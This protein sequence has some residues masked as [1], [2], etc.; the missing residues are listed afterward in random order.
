VGGGS[1]PR[2]GEISLAHHGVLFL[3]ELSEFARPSLEALRQP[4][5]EGRVAVVRGQLARMFP[6]RF[7]L[8]AATNP[9]P[10]GFA[11]D[12][13][14]SC[15]EAEIARHR[16]RLS[17]PLLDRLDLVV[18]VQRVTSAEL[19]AGPVCS[20]AE[21]RERVAAARERQAHRLAGS[22]ARCNGQMDASMVRAHVRLSAGAQRALLDAYQE[23]RLS[24]R[25]HQRVLRV[26]RTIADLEG[27]E[28][29]RQ[30]HV[31]RALQLRQH[32]GEA[33][34]VA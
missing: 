25:G 30:S 10:C 16:K 9:C 5:E 6:T 21:V 32:D 1:W 17:G 15:S 23:T 22:G 13:R 24:T 4:L 12:L 28:R 14:C 18:A 8:V 3:D 31:M 34:A 11:G 19:E 20:S 27:S 26:A 7:L 2:P 29:V 33:E